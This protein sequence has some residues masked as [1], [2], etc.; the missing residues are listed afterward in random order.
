MTDLKAQ[1]RDRSKPVFLSVD[2]KSRDRISEILSLD[3]CP[4]GH[5]QLTS[6]FEQ[7]IWLNLD[8]I[9]TINVLLE[10]NSDLPFKPSVILESRHH[11]EDGY[12]PDWDSIHWR[13]DALITGRSRLYEINEISGHDWITVITSI[14]RGLRFFLIT[15]DDGEEVAFQISDLDLVIGTEIGRYSNLQVERL[16]KYTRSNLCPRS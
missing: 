14:Q 1:F 12:E 4:T 15:D 8:H 7:D 3:K 13:V 6:I 11:H 9:Q 2:E 10:N 16:A 5:I